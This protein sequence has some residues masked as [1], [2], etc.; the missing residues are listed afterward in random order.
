MMQIILLFSIFK[1][2][3]KSDH[4]CAGGKL[5]PFPPVVIITNSEGTACS[6]WCLLYTQPWRCIRYKYGKT[7]DE[8]TL[9]IGQL[10]HMRSGNNVATSG[11]KTSALIL[12]LMKVNKKQVC[13][14]RAP[15]PRKPRPTSEKHKG[16]NEQE[17]TCEVLQKHTGK[18]LTKY[19]KKFMIMT[20]K[21]TIFVFQ[22]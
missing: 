6:E 19:I 9:E 14:L 11:E 21:S 1:C 13:M 16:T 17:N 22:M 2:G 5:S 3:L 18:I 15:A 8:K 7:T 20:V 10:H 12:L 4:G